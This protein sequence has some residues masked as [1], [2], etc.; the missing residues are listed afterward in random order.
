MKEWEKGRGWWLQTIKTHSQRSMKSSHFI[1]WNHVNN[2][3]QIQNKKQLFS[4]DIL[5][6]YLK[7][8]KNI[9][10]KYFVNF[11]I[12]YKGKMFLFSSLLLVSL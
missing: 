10:C 12:I 5:L 9:I 4:L 6:S 1:S 7:I 3:K 8:N 11:K 2:N